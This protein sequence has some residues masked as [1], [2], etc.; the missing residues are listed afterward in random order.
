MRF[1][2]PFYCS[3]ELNGPYLTEEVE[4]EEGG[5]GAALFGGLSLS[6]LPT[7]SITI[8]GVCVGIM[9]TYLISF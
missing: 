3:A 6:L 8:L 9:L 7:S 1:R 4:A 2:P 5:N